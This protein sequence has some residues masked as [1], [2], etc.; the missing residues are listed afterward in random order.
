[1][2]TTSKI[3]FIET[4]NSNRS[5]SFVSWV[6]SGLKYE[7]YSDENQILNE[8]IALNNPIFQFPKYDPQFMYDDILDIQSV[9]Q[10]SLYFET[11]NL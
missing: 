10:Y 3:D 7:L 2:W 5:H 1:M 8:S 6:L 4:Y 11:Y 9:E